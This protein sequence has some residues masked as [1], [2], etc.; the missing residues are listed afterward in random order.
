MNKVYVEKSKVQGRGVFAKKNIKKG[1]TIFVA[2]GKIRNFFIQTKQDS[3]NGEKISSR[4]NGIG[5]NT[6]LVASESSPLY[7]TNH[8]CDPNTGIKGKVIFVAMMDIKKDEEITFDYSIAE[9]DIYWEMK[10]KCGQKKCRKV[11]R[12]IQF[13][14]KKIFKTYLPYI[15]TYFKNVYLN[16]H[17]NN[18]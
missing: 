12:S 2:K 5:K 17:K 10:C 9:C 8:S 11:I 4:W 13:L 16:I 18:K 14:P 7:Y 15:P 6:W 1:E 3:L